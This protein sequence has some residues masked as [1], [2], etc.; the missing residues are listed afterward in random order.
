MSSIIKVIVSTGQGRLHLVES[1]VALKKNGAK[2]KM[3]TGWLP[4]KILPD[5][6]VNLLGRIIGRRNLVYGLRKR[7]SENLNDNEILSCASSEFFY[8]F[9]LILSKIKLLNGVSASIIGWKVYGW[10]SRKYIKDADVFHVRS[11]AGQGGAIAQAKRN[12][13]KVVVDQ[14]MAHPQEQYMQLT[15]ANKNYPV[16]INRFWEVLLLEDCN[17]A[18][19][20]LVNSEYVKNSFLKNGFIESS[21]VVANLGVRRDFLG[22][23]KDYTVTSEINLLFTGAFGLRKGAKIIFKSIKQLIDKNIDFNLDIVGPVAGDIKI[24]TWFSEHP[25]IHLHG[26]IQQGH[27]KQYL[28]ESDLFIFPS[29][30]EGSAQCLKEAMGAAMPVIATEQSGAPIIDGENG[31]IIKDDSPDALTLAILKLMKDKELR[32]RLGVNAYKTI[33]DKHSWDQYAK[34]VLNMYQ[35]LSENYFDKNI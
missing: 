28:S 26:H 30:C 25:K 19:I 1:T 11:G 27:L 21:I 23:K 10:Q 8:Q 24:P 29:Y 12:N 20:I 34:D 16:T 18:D 15:K 13:I 33:K 2:V 5:F 3:I 7:T 31:L 32:S 22:I 4:S 14:S 17:Q 6:F 35:R 9:L